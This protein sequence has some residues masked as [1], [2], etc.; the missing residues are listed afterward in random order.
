MSNTQPLLQSLGMSDSEDDN[1][2]PGII[3][4]EP[5]EMEV[6]DAKVVEDAD[7]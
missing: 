7:R 1:T 5:A 4:E 2:T 6:V 3:E